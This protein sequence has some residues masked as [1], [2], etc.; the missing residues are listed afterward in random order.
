M[1]ARAVARGQRLRAMCHSMCVRGRGPHRLPVRESRRVA[2]LLEVR[3]VEHL[4][5]ERTEA[6]MI[7]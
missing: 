1:C 2:E 4:W 7:L 6:Q 5:A 3:L